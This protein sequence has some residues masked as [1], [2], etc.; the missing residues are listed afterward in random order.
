[1]S[2]NNTCFI[3]NRFSLFRTSHVSRIIRARTT[4]P[5]EVPPAALMIARPCIS[6]NIKGYIK[7]IPL[8]ERS[9]TILFTRVWSL[10]SKLSLTLVMLQVIHHFIKNSKWVGSERNCESWTLCTF[11]DD[12]LVFILSSRRLERRKILIDG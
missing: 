11:S 7:A 5:T 8:F 6:Q 10:Y 12:F 1:M 9:K 2:F 4:R 3:F